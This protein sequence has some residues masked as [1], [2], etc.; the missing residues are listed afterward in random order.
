MLTSGD[1]SIGQPRLD[2]SR[3]LLTRWG[4]SVRTDWLAPVSDAVVYQALLGTGASPFA[5]WL[6]DLTRGALAEGIDTVVADE[7][8]GYNPSHDLCRVLANRLVGRLREA[9]RSVRSLEIPLVGHPCDPAREAQVEID[10][11]LN[12]AELRQKLDDVLDYAR[13]CSPVLLGEVQT[14]FDTFGTQ[15]FAREC[16]YPAARTPYEDGQEPATMPHFERVGEER[17]A[18]GIYK[19]VIRAR[20]LL[21]MVTDADPRG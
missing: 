12:D 4:L 11:R 3:K 7:A 20:H 6:D 19:N 13:R 9:G 10:V 17:Q 8:E 2:D 21:R 18:A 1:G 16:L 14:M 15:A 5:G